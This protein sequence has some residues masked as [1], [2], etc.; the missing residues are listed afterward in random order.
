MY[1]MANTGR[2]LPYVSGFQPGVATPEGSWTILEGLRTILEGLRLDIFM[3]TAIL[4]LVY[5]SF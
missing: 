1:G 4:Y 2:I 3:Y 5:S